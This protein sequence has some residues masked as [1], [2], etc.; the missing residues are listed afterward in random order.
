[1]SWR[2]S[3]PG[4]SRTRTL[5]ERLGSPQK[6]LSF[7]HIAGTNGK[8]STAAMLAS[9][10]RAA[11]YKTG[12]YTSPYVTCFNER[13][14]IDGSFIPDEDLCALV[15][16]VAPLAEAMA[17]PPTEFE[18]ITALAMLYFAE[19]RCDLVV[20]E[21]GMGGRLDSTNVIDAPLCAII[22]NIGLDHTRELG[23]TVEKI[24]AEKCGILKPG[25][26]AVLYAQTP[27]VEQVV[28]ERCAALG[29][30]LRLTRP[31][32]LVQI[33]NSLQGQRFSY[34]GQ[35]YRVSLFGAHQLR[36]AAVV[37][38]AVDVLRE[39]GLALP[40]EAVR[41]GLGAVRWPGRFE[42]VGQRPAFVVDVGHNPQCAETVA[43]C[44]R[45]YFPG[46]FTVLLLGVLA[47]KDYRGLVDILTPVADA[48][49]AA[50]PESPR[51]LPADA[52]AEVLLP[53]GK[54]VLTAKD[55]PEGVALARA[56]AG[57]NG[58]VVCTGSFYLAGKVRE[59][60]EALHEN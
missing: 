1:M 28:R 22:T 16:R 45:T 40:Q 25:T 4:L 41:R 8:G 30:P 12:L 13:I 27:G 15:E 6:Q 20:L 7:V 31:E 57:E 51:A 33:E 59:I 50:A 38:E 55:I 52:L 37:L 43:D 35:E 3:K 47:D 46:V 48:F 32:E 18:L 14:Q 21:V 39:R 10:L 26:S 24:A 34:R 58:L 23:D 36:N 60:V 49:V 9:V 19:R 53:A 42:L 54:P 29:V 56:M 44:V 11:G 2:G 5:L 17:D